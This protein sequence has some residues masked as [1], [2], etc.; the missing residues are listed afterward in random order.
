MGAFPRR[1]V[2]KVQSS[3]IRTHPE[4][5]FTVLE[6]RM[7]LIAAKASGFTLI[8]PV[9]NKRF[10][11]RIVQVEPAPISAGPYPMLPVLKKS[12]DIVIAE[13]GGFARLIFEMS[14]RVFA[15]VEY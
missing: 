13:T 4:T 3:P 5:P 8:M 10:F 1:P 7:D 11:T 6:D 2:K 15:P 9:M 14:E 12:P